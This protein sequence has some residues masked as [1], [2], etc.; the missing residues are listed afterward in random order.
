MLGNS[1]KS[2]GSPWRHTGHGNEA[3]R[4]DDGPSYLVVVIEFM[5]ALA[6]NDNGN[7]DEEEEDEG[8]EGADDEA[9]VLV[10]LRRGFTGGVGALPGRA[11]APL[12]GRQRLPLLSN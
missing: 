6:H 12:P 8:G 4:L 3:K 2:R 1:Y 10:V 9:E 7:E 11:L 5:F